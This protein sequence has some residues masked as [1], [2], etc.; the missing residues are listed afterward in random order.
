M[1]LQTPTLAQHTR[2]LFLVH[3]S[4][5]GG[6]FCSTQLLLSPGELGLQAS[7]SRQALLLIIAP[8]KG[9]CGVASH[10]H[11]HGPARGHPRN[12][13][14]V[15]LAKAWL[16]RTSEEV[17]KRFPGGT[18]KEAV[19]GVS[20]ALHHPTF[21][22]SLWAA[23]VAVLCACFVVVASEGGYAEFLPSSLLVS[24]E[25][26]SPAGSIRNQQ[27]RARRAED[28]S[29]CVHPRRPPGGGV[30]ESG[31]PCVAPTCASP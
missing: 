17:R 13:A 12:S 15:S 28:L 25:S 10:G 14:G 26:W 11:F 4:W 3:T 27:S 1:G 23:F 30:P 16:L 6:S 7:F 20:E 2:G 31:Y 24:V 8:Q 22:C 19:A 29:A 18:W 9:P 5:P 21:L